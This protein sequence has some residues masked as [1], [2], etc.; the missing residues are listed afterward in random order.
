MQK[1]LGFMIL[2]A[3]LVMPL[4][5]HAEGNYFKAGV[6]SSEYKFEELSENKTAVNIAYGFSLNKNFDV[7]LGYANLGKLKTIDGD[8]SVQTQSFY[9]AGVGNLPL[10]DAFSAFGKVGV[11]VNH[12]SAKET[13]FADTTETKARGLLGLGLAYNFTKEVAGTLEY[14]Y[15]GTVDQVR[16]SALTLG[17][18]YGF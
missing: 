14:Q 9:V 1:K 8:Y 3:A 17:V 5:A 12:F 7:E 6:G 10:T 16:I 4:A 2:S 15:F 18:K 11:A 13:G